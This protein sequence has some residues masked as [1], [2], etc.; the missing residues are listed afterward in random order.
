MVA[1]GRGG[2]NYD[3]SLE[4]C[5]CFCHEPNS[6]KNHV[7]SCCAGKCLMC[8]RFINFGFEDKHFGNCSS[9]NLGKIKDI[10]IFN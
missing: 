3:E 1:P 4:F 9:P 7:V 10:I 2:C 8:A 5:H 6:T